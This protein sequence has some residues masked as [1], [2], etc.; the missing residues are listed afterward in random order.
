M[1]TMTAPVITKRK[2]AMFAC[3]K[4]KT[5]FP[6]YPEAKLYFA[7]VALAVMDLSHGGAL[8]R[9]AER[10]L[11]GTIHAAEV[12]GVDSAW[13]RRVLRQFDLDVVA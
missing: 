11:R 3:E 2:R 12:C 5:Q 9:A 6:T 1:N 7:V 4:I 13:I 10:Y 8:R